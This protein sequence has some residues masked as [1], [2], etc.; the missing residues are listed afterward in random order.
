MSVPNTAREMPLSI[1][2][3][4]HILSSN[5]VGADALRSQTDEPEQNA[6]EPM[7]AAND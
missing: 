4:F 5:L 3:S 2:D 1:E 7:E 6:S